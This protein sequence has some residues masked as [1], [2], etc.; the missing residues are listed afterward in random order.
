MNKKEILKKYFNRYFLTALNGMA[1]GLFA[2]LI[3]GTMLS[4]IIQ[5]PFLS[6][7]SPI[8]DVLSSKELIYGAAIG[9]G[10]S[11]A[12]KHKPLV[13]VSAL[14]SGAVAI[15]Q[16]GGPLGAFLASL[17]ACEIGGLISGKTKIDIIVTP[18]VT[19]IVGGLV[20]ILTSP[21]IGELMNLLGVV[22]NSATDQN[23]FIMGVVIAVIVGITLTL[24]ISSAAICIS[25]EISGLAA[26]A[27]VV[28]CCAQMMG[29]AIQS[30]KKDGIS[31]FI[32]V[33]IGT[34]MLQ[35]PN[36]VRKPAIWLPT[37]ITSAI[38][39][40][41]S[42]CLF[43]L[44]NSSVGAGMGTCGLVGQINAFSS[45]EFSFILL[46]QVILL[47]IILPLVL[48]FSFNKLFIKM[49]VYCEDDLKLYKEENDEQN[50]EV[51]I[52]KINNENNEE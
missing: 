45:N 42:T 36:I 38:L 21:I 41:V 13:T 34:S 6:F 52:E 14:V 16:G 1:I 9:C 30:I 24:P 11:L 23:P 29:F 5:I 46:V 51:K 3:I 15:N 26:G 48:V 40:P 7:L 8:T 12:L 18:L 25:L 37:I 20:A 19:I 47:H 31:G 10:V 35:F 17:V 22:I 39:G 4:T 49:N 44:S 27:A 2:S 33:G 43:K 32:S 50:N 28:G